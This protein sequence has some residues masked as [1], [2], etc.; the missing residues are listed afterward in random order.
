MI[1]KEFVYF[2][3]STV[4]QAILDIF[5]PIF[6]HILTTEYPAITRVLVVKKNIVIM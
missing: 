2:L 5:V 4:V 6:V 1:L 3:E